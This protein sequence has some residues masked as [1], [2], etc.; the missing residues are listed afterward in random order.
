MAM[1]FHNDWICGTAK[2]CSLFYREEL[3][4]RWS[5]IRPMILCDDL[6]VIEWS[7]FLCRTERENRMF[8]RYRRQDGRWVEK[9]WWDWYIHRMCCLQPI[10]LTDIYT[11][12]CS[13]R[14]LCLMCTTFWFF[15]IPQYLLCTPHYTIWLPALDYQCILHSPILPGKRKRDETGSGF[16]AQDPPRPDGFWPVDPTRPS[17]WVFWSNNWAKKQ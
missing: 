1:F 3:L 9:I 12:L 7:W 14:A 5:S 13:K 17:L 6:H 10:L 15:D 4:D 16:L 8:G 11:D 2:V